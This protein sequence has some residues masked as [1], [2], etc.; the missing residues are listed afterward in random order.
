M[1]DNANQMEVPFPED[2]HCE[3]FLVCPSRN[4]LCIGK[5]IFF[6]FC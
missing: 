6:A 3:Q 5:E 4:F 1:V 2:S